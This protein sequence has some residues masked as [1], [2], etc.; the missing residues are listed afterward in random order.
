MYMV[1]MHIS[2]GVFQFNR[3]GVLILPSV[4]AVDSVEPYT[5]FPSHSTHRCAI[6]VWHMQELCLLSMDLVVK[7]TF[8]KDDLAVGLKKPIYKGRLS[9]NLVEGVLMVFF[10]VSSDFVHKLLA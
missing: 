4:D 10:V 6:R 2:K 3:V 1:L 8:G 5:A 9:V 7:V